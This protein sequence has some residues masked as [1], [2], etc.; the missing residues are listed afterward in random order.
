MQTR[1]CMNTC[2]IWNVFPTDYSGLEGAVGY[3]E[4]K[5]EYIPEWTDPRN[6]EETDEMHEMRRRRLARFSSPEEQTSEPGHK[7]KDNIDLDWL[8]FPSP[9][10]WSELWYESTKASSLPVVSEA[11]NFSW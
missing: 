1:S 11:T 10:G 9:L 5:V 8:T 3:S 4:P 7:V 6:E 2:D